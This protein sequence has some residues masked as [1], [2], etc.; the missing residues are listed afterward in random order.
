M[1]PRIRL[2]FSD[3]WPDFN[4]HDNYF[5]QLLRNKYEVVVT[6]QP[7]FLIY[8]CFGQQFR[9]H[10]G[11]R[12]FYTGENR[13]PDFRECDFAFTFD[14]CNHPNHL[15]LPLWRHG[16]SIK[17][18]PS[19]QFLDARAE[20]A[21]KTGFCSFVYSN[22]YCP[23]RNRF[24]RLLSKYKRV[25][26]AGKLFNNVGYQLG[27]QL[28]DKL[29]FI[30]HYKFTIAFENESFPGYTTEKLY[31]PMLVNSLPIYW[32]DPRVDVDFN[33]ASFINYFDYGSFEALVQQVIK[34]DQD[35]ELYC[36]YLRQPWFR[37]NLMHEDQMQQ[38]VLTQFDRIFSM[39]NTP[40]AQQPKSARYF[41]FHA[42]ERTIKKMKLKSM[43]QAHKI[44]YRLELLR[45]GKTTIPSS[46]YHQ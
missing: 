29:E 12:I 14:F 42:A 15:R 17:Q 34:V 26:A 22:K 21:K 27:P 31:E 1:Q 28:T 3:F 35:D 37:E 40:V 44:S 43:R 11:W 19:K 8:S 9:R 41:I 16:N 2:G 24:F 5:T 36:H 4:P 13:R 23:I 30:R 10:H 18:P 38:S 45:F 33:P 20:L 32:G 46:R 6:G 25:D 7:D 39:R